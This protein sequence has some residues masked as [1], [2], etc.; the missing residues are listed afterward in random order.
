MTAIQTFSL[1]LKTG[2]GHGPT[3]NGA[4]TDGDVY[5][6]LCGREFHIDTTSDDFE[7]NSDRT[8]IFGLGH[9]IRYPTFNDPRSGYGIFTEDIDLTPA[10]IRFAPKGREDEW[11]LESATVSV[12]NGE[13][14]LQALDDPAGDNLWLSTHS[15]LYI[16]LW[17]VAPGGPLAR[18]RAKRAAVAGV[19]TK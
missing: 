5:I 12:N 16:Y 4:G 8:Y 2:S 13:V 10:Y 14:R 17:T 18:A 6:G 7:S 9:N 3:N 15:G 1:R 11:R 19:G